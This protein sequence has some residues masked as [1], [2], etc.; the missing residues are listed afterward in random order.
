MRLL[1]LKR[2]ARL[3]LALTGSER[4][5]VLGSSSLLAT[6][7]EL[8][9]AGQILSASYDA[10]LL[11]EPD[12]E[13]LAKILFEALGAERAFDKRFG[14]HVDILRAAIKD[15]LPPGWDTRLVPLAD[16][17]GVFCLE[18]HD[19]AV[20]KLHASRPKDLGVLAALLATGRLSA[21]TVRE[22]LDKTRMR[23]AVIVRT[24]DGLKKAEAMAAEMR[25]AA[26]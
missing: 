9:E 20:A 23:E 4:I 10:D 1:A 24:Y 14:Y 17:P 26:A 25:A 6:F 19:L 5:I 11:L 13:D 8:G 3:A 16:C 15:S 2:V 21:A 22:R 18:P 7:G 12:D